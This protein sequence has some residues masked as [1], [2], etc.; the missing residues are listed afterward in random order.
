MN[1]VKTEASR[2]IARALLCSLIGVAGP[3]GLGCAADLTAGDTGSGDVNASD[4]GVQS[5]SLTAA[6]VR[7]IPKGEPLTKAGVVAYQVEPGSPAD[8]TLFSSEKR[9]VLTASI[10][11]V[12]PK[13][14][15]DSDPPRATVHTANGRPLGVATYNNGRDEAPDW[16][17]SQQSSSGDS[18]V[19]CFLLCLACSNTGDLEQCVR[20]QLCLDD[21]PDEEEEEC[22]PDTDEDGCECP[23]E[24]MGLDCDDPVSNPAQT[25]GA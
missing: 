24:L 16:E 8:M 22:D 6:K 1:R 3:M 9:P 10:Y 20:C 13:N 5:S 15:Q 4:V 18:G 17:T 11:D 12:D 2:R 25:Q 23:Q 21:L 19:T 7:W 14:P